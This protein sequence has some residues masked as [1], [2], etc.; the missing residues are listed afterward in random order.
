MIA[1]SIM[2]CSLA[3]ICWRRGGQT[4]CHSNVLQRMN[5]FPTQLFINGDFVRGHRA[6]RI[7]QIDPATEEAFV[8]VEAASVNDIDVAVNGAERAFEF[9]WRDLTPGKRADIL[10]RIA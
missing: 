9:M 6:K 5:D 10:F 8:E 4:R 2:P 1:T 3:S 7:A